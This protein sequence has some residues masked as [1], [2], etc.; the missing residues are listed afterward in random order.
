MF[1]VSDLLMM[2][3]SST[4]TTKDQVMVDRPFIKSSCQ[5]KQLQRLVS[6]CYHRVPFASGLT[7]AQIRTAV[8]ATLIEDA[9]NAEL[10]GGQR[11][12]TIDGKKE[13]VYAAAS[14]GFA[15]GLQS[16]HQSKSAGY[17]VYW[18]VQDHVTST[19]ASAV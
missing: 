12:M 1:P 13:E 18:Y 3:T 17:C 8:T 4:S 10:L 11:V 9:T 6:T 7:R 5:L 2:Q 14:C 19:W 16:G 15:D